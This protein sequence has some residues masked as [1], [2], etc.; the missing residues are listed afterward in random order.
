MADVLVKRGNLGTE[1][2]QRKHDVERWGEDSRMH[3]MDRGW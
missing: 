3:T 1:A 2:A